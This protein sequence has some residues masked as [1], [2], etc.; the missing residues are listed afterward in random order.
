MAGGPGC[1]GSKFYV[2]LGDTPWLD[3]KRV[4]FGHLVLGAEVLRAIGE[5]GE[6][7]ERPRIAACGEYKA[8]FPK[9]AMPPDI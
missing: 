2:C 9:A 8:I 4:V 3:G 1:V 5:L 6:G 7:G